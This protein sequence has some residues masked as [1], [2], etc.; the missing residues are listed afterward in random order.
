MLTSSRSVEP[1]DMTRLISAIRLSQRGRT[2]AADTLLESLNR[3]K[4]FCDSFSS[5]AS[6]P[7]G[8]SESESLEFLSRAFINENYDLAMN[9]FR[10]LVQESKASSHHVDLMLSTLPPRWDDIG[11]VLELVSCYSSSSLGPS[12]STCSRLLHLLLPPSPTTSNPTPNH[13]QQQ[14]QHNDKEKKSDSLQL[15]ESMCTTLKATDMHEHEIRSEF[16]Y[17]YNFFCNLL[18][19]RVADSRHVSLM[20]RHA[21]TGRDAERVAKISSEHGLF[22]DISNQ[23]SVL[24][25]LIEDG[26]EER[27][28][29]YMANHMNALDNT[30]VKQLH[31]LVQEGRSDLARD[32]FRKVLEFGDDTSVT[33]CLR[34]LRRSRDRVLTL[35]FI[36]KARARGVA[37]AL[38]WWT[39][40]DWMHDDDDDVV[41]KKK[42]SHHN[43]NDDKVRNLLLG[44]LDHRRYDVD[45][46]SSQDDDTYSRIEMLGICLYSSLS[47]SLSSSNTD[48]DFV[49]F[50]SPHLEAKLSTPSSS[51]S[52]NDEEKEE[53][54]EQRQQQ[55]SQQ[56]QQQKLKTNL[57]IGRTQALEGF[58][59]VGRKDIALKLYS[60]YHHQ[61]HVDTV[62]LNLMLTRYCENADEA[63]KVAKVSV[64]RGVRLNTESERILRSKFTFEGREMS[65]SLLDSST[66][67]PSLSSVNNTA[68]KMASTELRRKVSSWLSCRRGERESW[69]KFKKRRKRYKTEMWN[70]YQDIFRRGLGNV[71][72]CN[73]M[74]TMLP[75]SQSAKQA[76][77]IATSNDV[78]FDVKTYTAMT[79]QLIKE[80]QFVLARRWIDDLEQSGLRLDEKARSLRRKLLHQEFLS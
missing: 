27:A 7:L 64:A 45:W 35:E 79:T 51:S 54:N 14:Q 3:P 39:G 63:A 6:V 68:S 19:D 25:K 69:S 57:N 60:Q 50:V 33:S 17:A 77:D 5:Y 15:L 1:D 11:E 30:D 66:S 16:S 72:H 67:S 73:V 38:D 71:V 13:H 52:H 37:V 28:V 22:L 74:V 43:G 36:A 2:E 62:M 56:Q 41:K 76:L 34:A 78:E 23:Y 44:D 61:G 40:L 31:K 53:E 70:Y 49:K 42:K 10:I 80:N 20:L 12:P 65:S 58:I 8:L 59:R 26:D 47:S 21:R 55:C 48:D 24:S 29:L 4:L 18:K 75:T 32:Y 9:F 46:W